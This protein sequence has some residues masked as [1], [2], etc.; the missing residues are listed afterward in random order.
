MK[1]KYLNKRKSENGNL[2][3]VV[4]NFLNELD[5]QDEVVSDCVCIVIN[6]LN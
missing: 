1:I 3:D 4:V 2:L 6:T 5:V